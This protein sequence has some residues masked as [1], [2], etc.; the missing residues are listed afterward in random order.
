[1]NKDIYAFFFYCHYQLSTCTLKKNHLSVKD[2]V[3][4]EWNMKSPVDNEKSSTVC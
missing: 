1:M 2:Y 3:S 4:S